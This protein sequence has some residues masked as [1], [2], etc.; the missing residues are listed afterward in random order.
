[1]AKLGGSKYIW[2]IC[3][4][5]NV[6]FSSHWL[7]KFKILSEAASLL[8]QMTE[9][10]HGQISRLASI[11]LLGFFLPNSTEMSS[12]CFRIYHPAHI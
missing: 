5:F 11:L 12:F 3:V 9:H 1:M 4:W 2:I 6:R 7:F 8:P 10:E